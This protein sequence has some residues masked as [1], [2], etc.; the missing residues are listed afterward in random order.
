MTTRWQNYST[1]NSWLLYTACSVCVRVYA[2]MWPW[3]PRGKA[4]VSKTE[5]HGFD[6]RPRFLINIQTLVSFYWG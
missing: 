6:P 2:A 5:G 4:L 3:W 1:N